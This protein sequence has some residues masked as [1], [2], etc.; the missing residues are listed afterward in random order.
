LDFSFNSSAKKKTK[1]A[2]LDSKFKRT[3]QTSYY[4]PTRR[5]REENKSGVIFA[6]HYHCFTNIATSKKQSTK[7]SSST[8]SVDQ[9]MNSNFESFSCLWLD[10]NVSSS[11]DNLE[12]QKELREVINHLRTFDNS[13]ECEEYIREITKEKV[14]LI[15]SGSAGR[16]I[17]PKLHDLPQFSACYV[18]C[19]DK[20]ANE[21]WANKYHKVKR[22]ISLILLLIDLHMV[23]KWSFC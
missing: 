14:V 3:R 6:C 19:Q 10:Q 21:Q 22:F 16:Q 5:K 2:L 15:V 9:L 13:D 17:V 12:T 1:N 23:G 18:F 20:K 11:Q 4:L 7:V 8:K